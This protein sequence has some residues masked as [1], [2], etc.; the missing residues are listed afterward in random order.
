MQIFGQIWFLATQCL[1]EELP[2]SGYPQYFVPTALEDREARMLAGFNPLDVFFQ[3]LLDIEVDNVTA[4]HHKRCNLTVI[5]AE[6][7]TDHLV[8]FM[9]DHPGAGALR[10]HQVD[11]LLS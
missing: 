3:R 4:W 9:L 1:G 7:I 6:Y 11:F 8:L 2:R 10:K 5:Q